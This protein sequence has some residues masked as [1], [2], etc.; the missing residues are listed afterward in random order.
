MGRAKYGSAAYAD[1]G[2]P[3]FEQGG[4]SVVTSAEAIARRFRESV[5]LGEPW[6]DALLRAVHEWRLPEE[7]A[8]GR[9]FRYLIQGEAFDWLALAERL[10]EEVTDLVPVEEVEDL[11]F[12][13]AL[14][15]NLDEEDFRDAIGASKHRA[16]LSF[17]YGVTVEESLQLAV[18]EE[19]HKERRSNAL[20]SSARL[21][22]AVFERLYHCRFEELLAEFR[23]TVPGPGGTDLGYQERKEF[24][25]WLFKYRLSQ[26]DRARVA[27][28]TRKGL[29]QLSQLELASKR[30]RPTAVDEAPD[31]GWLEGV[32]RVL[33]GGG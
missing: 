7:N 17:L 16:H 12:S 8:F 2:H 20:G 32:A 25:Y 1:D 24:T 3:G 5:A 33:D 13:G 15:D 27:S 6:F 9:H 28:D 14:P 18:E 22:E 19:I 23:G 21:H 31:E 29:A 4:G 11:L 30:R 10:L 26:H